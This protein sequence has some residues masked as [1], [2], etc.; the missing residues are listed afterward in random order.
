MDLLI[1]NGFV[2]DPANGRSGYMNVLV[3]DDTIADIGPGVKGDPDRVIDADGCYVMPG[4]IDMHTH[5]REPGFREKETIESG[6]RAAARGGFTTICAMPNTKPVTDNPY[7]VSDIIRQAD[8]EALIH[9]LVIGAMTKGQRG[10]ETANIEGMYD[11]GII[12]VSEDGRSVK[13]AAV[14]LEAMKEAAR[15]GLPV[16]DHCEDADLAD[17]GVFNAGPAAER[18]HVK[19][20]PGAAE[21]SI[22]ARDIVLARA[23]GAHLHLCHVSTKES[24][25]LV[26]LAKESGTDISAEV[27]PHH[28]TLCDEDIDSADAAFKMNPPLRSREDMEALREALRA[29][30]IDVIATD[31][32]PHTQAEKDQ[33]LEKAPF[34]IVGLETAL[35]LTYTTLVQGGYLTPMQMVEKMSVNPAKIIGIRRGSLD[36]GAKADITVFDPHAEYTIDRNSFVSKGKNTPFHGRRVYGRVR[37]TVVNGRVV[38]MSRA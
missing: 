16:F 31:H 27:T 21:D 29:G 19:G 25:L 5:L 36:I 11:E 17:G 8:N 28:F 13:N 30:I 26:H 33:A 38:Y 22:A 3:R 4:L 9:V 14:C 34:G 7:T 6:A 2:L 35:P 1:T 12:A 24:T 18:F 32:A 37:A 20:I 10:E 23:A 15:L